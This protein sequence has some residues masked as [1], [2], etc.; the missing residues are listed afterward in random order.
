MPNWNADQKFF[1]ANEKVRVK[2]TDEGRA[3]LRRYKTAT[4][5]ELDST[6]FSLRAAIAA[7]CKL[8]PEV[9]GWTE[10]CL[11]ELLS[12]F[13]AAMTPGVDLFDMNIQ[14]DSSQLKARPTPH[15]E[16]G[17]LLLFQTQERPESRL[18]VAAVQELAAA[19]EDRVQMP[20]LWLRG[21]ARW[22]RPSAGDGVVT[23]VVPRQQCDR[24]HS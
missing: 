1:N 23:R 7:A 15:G 10:M 19:H 11:H 24:H 5:R 6:S 14:L 22:A 20:R 13:G 17:R 3:L 8:P 9:D 16:I 21:S 4:F 12:L 18:R 2:L